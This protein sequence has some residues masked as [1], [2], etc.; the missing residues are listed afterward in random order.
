MAPAEDT[1]RFERRVLLLMALVQFTNI[2]DFM[3]VMPLGPDFARS[4]GIDAGHI[5]WIAGSYSIAAAIT[6]VAIARFLDRF[7]RRSV[8]LFSFSALAVTTMAMITAHTLSQLIAIRIITGVFG[9]PTIASSLAV[10]A[11]VFPEQRRGE[12]M[13]KVLGS[14]SIASIIGVPLALEIARMWGWRSPFIA[15]SILAAITVL[16][17]RVYLPPLRH[18]IELQKDNRSVFYSLRH[19]R[20]MLPSFIMTA[21]GLFASFLI[22]PNISAHVQENMGY[23]R[24]WLGLLYFCGGSAAFFSMRLAGKLSDRI[25]YG[26]T[27]LYATIGL[28]VILYV[29]FYA[30][31]HTIPILLVFVGFMICMSTRNVTISALLSEIPA[32]QERAGFMSL[33]SAVQHLMSGVG[34]MCSTFLLVETP[35]GRLSGMDHVTLIAIVGFALS[36][37]MMLWVEKIM[38]HHKPV[39]PIEPVL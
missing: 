33:N 22:I 8:L 1:K 25:G 9:G 12:A 24:A 3:I 26:H 16:T 30:Q 19:N 36:M 18:H 32:P 31:I 37:W 4:L 20:A 14:F 5:G 13:G 39:E 28:A 11:D 35:D 29:G 21:T 6:G 15:V 38:E 34:S 27:S 7:D 17:I 2:L 10:I 23:P